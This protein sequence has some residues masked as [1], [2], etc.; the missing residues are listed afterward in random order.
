MSLNQPQHS[1]IRGIFD[2]TLEYKDS[3]FYDITSWTMPLAFGLPYRE[4]STP[5]VMGDKLADNPW[6]AQ[7]I[8]GGKTEYAYV[9][10][11]EEL[12]APAALNELVQAGYIVKVA[13]QPFEIQVSTGTKKFSAGSIVIPVRMQ[14]ENSEA[15]FSRVSAV[16]EKYKVTTWSVSSGKSSMGSDLGSARQATIPKPSVAMITG[17]GVDVYKRQV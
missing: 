15:V 3:I 17:P 10:Q 5:F 11:W 13:T 4:I 14:K 6:A 16:T 7:K 9:M 12:Y 2:K 8:N 1:L